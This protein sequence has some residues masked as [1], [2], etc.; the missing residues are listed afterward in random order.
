VSYLNRLG[1]CKNPYQTNTK[2]V[3]AVCSA[4]LLRSPTVANVL[5]Q[6]YGYNTRACGYNKEYAL[7]P[8]DD[9]LVKWADEIVCV[10]KEVLDGVQ[11][12]LSDAI[13]DKRVVCLNLPD[14]FEW[15]GDELRALISKQYQDASIM[16][17]AFDAP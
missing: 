6:E 13:K 15:N 12:V 3:L 4:G 14:R 17:K 1:N 2:K 8:I 7:I 10:E 5:H 16:E 9:V 11:S